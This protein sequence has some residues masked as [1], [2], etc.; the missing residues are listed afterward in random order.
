MNNKVYN[1]AMS[2]DI[3]PIGP[4][5]QGHIPRL[6]PRVEQSNN[7]DGQKPDAVELSEQA[8]MDPIIASDAASISE[9]V[10]KQAEKALRAGEGQPKT[11]T[12]E[13]RVEATNQTGDGGNATKGHPRQN[14]DTFA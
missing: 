5:P 6:P 14:L 1:N 7:V 9:D 11:P 3:S 13:R 12:P 2:S 8:A 4:S 10:R